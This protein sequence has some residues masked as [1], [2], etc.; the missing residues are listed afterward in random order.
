MLTDSHCHLS[1]LPPDELK[2]VLE[3]A[4]ENGVTTLVAIGAGYG[5]EGNVKTL[6]IANAHDHIYCALGMHPHDAKDVTDEN[7]EKLRSLIKANKKV[8]AVGEIG[9]DYHYMN[10]PKEVQQKVLRQFVQLACEA[11][12]PVAI[13]NRACGDDCVMILKQEKAGTMG[14][15]AHCFSE[16]KE[17][18]QKYLD[19]GFY[20]SFSGI[21]TFKKA[22]DLREVV[23]YVPLDRML[24]ETDS[25]FLAPEP[26]RGKQNE[27][28]FVRLVA[29]KVAQVKEISFEEM[30][31]KTTENAKK[32]FKL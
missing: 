9:L 29:E 11:K 19:L 24:I 20:I 15:V 4:R 7:L 12:K 21:I 23:K 30:A 6:N 22:H 26:Y 13:H 8:C 10:S 31:N 25:P 14:G 18:A 27:P 1:E 17:L 5:F 2:G 28:A 16:S 3:R 32:L